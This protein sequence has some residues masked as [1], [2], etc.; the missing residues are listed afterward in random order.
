MEKRWK[1]EH[2]RP[3]VRN[4]GAAYF[5][6]GAFWEVIDCVSVCGRG[7]RLGNLADSWGLEIEILRYF[8]FWSQVFFVPV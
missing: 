1:G 2:S 3:Y 8:A 5:G 4:F 6:V 7:A